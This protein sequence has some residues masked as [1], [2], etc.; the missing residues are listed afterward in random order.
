[1]FVRSFQV[2][3]EDIFGDIRTVDLKNDGGST[4]VTTQNRE[5]YVN[6]CVQVHFDGAISPLSLSMFA[7]FYQY[8]SPRYWIDK[9]F[10]YQ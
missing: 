7:R 4:P 6:L 1:M 8:S 2:S 3:V 10:A 9:C 5:E